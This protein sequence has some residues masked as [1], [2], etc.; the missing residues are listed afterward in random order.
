MEDR[1]DLGETK[2][3]YTLMDIRA[4]DARTFIASGRPGDL[5]LAMLAR[6]GPERMLEIAERASEKESCPN[7]GCCR[8]LP[9][10]KFGNLPKWVDTRL[11]AASSAQIERWSKKTLSA[12]TLEGVLG[13]K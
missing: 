3:A 9:E 1:V 8:G 12:D 7:S 13:K 5:V 2:S 4:M 6:G 11:E 10:T